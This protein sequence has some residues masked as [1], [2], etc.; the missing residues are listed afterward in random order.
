MGKLCL[1]ED[2]YTV[3]W[4]GSLAM[5]QS[6]ILLSGI[7]LIANCSLAQVS[8][9]GPQFENFSWCVLCGHHVHNLEAALRF[10]AREDLFLTFLFPCSAAGAK[11]ERSHSFVGTIRGRYFFTNYQ[12]FCYT[13]LSPRGEMACWRWKHFSACGL[14]CTM[15]VNM[16][17]NDAVI[18]AWSFNHPKIWESGTFSSALWEEDESPGLK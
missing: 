1:L 7:H 2:T 14:D 4:V 11:T 17:L 6:L 15:V 9:S 12:S 16:F 3:S 5:L 10:G 18:L 13:K 8:L